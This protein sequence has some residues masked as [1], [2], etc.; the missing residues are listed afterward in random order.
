MTRTPGTFVISLDFEL[1]WG[2][3]DSRTQAEYGDAILGAR[4]AIP[5]M[6]SRFAQHG[7]RAT[8]ATVGLRRSPYPLLPQIGL[9]EREDPLHFGGELIA[10]IADTPGQEIATHTFSHYYTLEPGPSLA[11]FE[12]DIAVAKEVASRDGHQIRSIV[13][14]RNQMTPAHIAACLR[15]GLGASSNISLRRIAAR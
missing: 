5:Q 4:A 14:P 7:I 10:R 3:H 12:A 2:V 15:H 13:F 6:L 1:M 9:N 8:W 11:A